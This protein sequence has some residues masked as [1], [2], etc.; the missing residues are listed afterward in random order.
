[1]RDEARRLERLLTRLRT[2]PRQDCLT[3][4]L[5]V[6]REGY[7]ER[8]YSALLQ[9]L[10]KRYR[11][12]LSEEERETV[13]R[14]LPRLH[15]WLEIERPAG[16]DGLA[17]FGCEAA[18]L[19]E[20]LRLPEPPEARLEVGAPLLAP[21]DRMLEEHPP[22]LV[23]VV[24][25]EKARLFGSILGELLAVTE[26]KGEEVKHSKAGWTSAPSNQR[27]ADNRAARNLREVARRL[28]Q[29]DGGFY[30]ELWVVGPPEA[31]TELIRALSDRLRA[32]HREIA[33]SSLDKPFG[34]TLADIRAHLA[35]AR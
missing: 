25:K 28:D 32:L 30:R 19:R 6:R 16:C 13:G 24:D 18:G 29:E 10:V 17:M 5:P 8:Y 26:M 23:A 31:R 22:A 3:L 33:Q 14:E 9:G 12:R 20:A 2:L 7:D 1:M 27:K 15:H 21:I 4:Y 11:D 35:A 34:E